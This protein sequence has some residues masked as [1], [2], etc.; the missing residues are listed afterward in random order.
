MRV[1]FV[2]MHGAGNDFVVVDRRPLTL[3]DSD[4]AAFVQAVCDRRRGVGA[5]GV[6]FLEAGPDG[7]DFAMRYHN[8]DGGEAELCG[9]GGRCLA[10]FAVARGFGD[11]GRVRFVSP[12]GAHEARVEDGRVALVLGD[13]EA[14]RLGLSLDTPLGAIEAAYL[15]VGVPHLVV[16]VPDASAVDLAVLAPVLRAHPE[17]GAEGANVDVAQVTGPDRV[18]LRTFER[19]VEGETL[20]CG[21]GAAATAIALTARGRVRAPVTLEVESGDA[22]TVRFDAVKDG[23]GAVRSVTLV[24]PVVTSFEGS[25]DW[26]PPGGS[27]RARTDR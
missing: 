16:E 9:N 18:R 22:L 24:G 8:R 1:A 2:K 25:F 7:F 21:T 20:A 14:P 4:V 15:K 5:D 17:L 12:A 23:G 3:D 11:G 27:E 10:A 6:L 19:G 26:Q 13:A